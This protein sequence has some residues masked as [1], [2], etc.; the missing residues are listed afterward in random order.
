[1]KRD[2]RRLALVQRQAMLARIARQQALRG[3]AEALEAEARS[4]ALARKS[5]RLLGAIAARPGDTSG[6]A[7]AERSAFAAGLAQLAG[8]AE[9]AAEDAVRQSAWA[10]DTLARAET[11]SQ[12]LA[13]REDEAHAALR[14]A[15]DRTDQADNAFAPTLARKL[16]SS[17]ED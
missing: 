13:Q 2:A 8:N 14:A 3:L 12:R 7:L 17:G 6:S 10:A 1:M 9:A 11:R 16:H 4:H 5:R 15:R